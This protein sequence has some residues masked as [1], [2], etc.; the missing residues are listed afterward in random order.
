MCERMSLIQNTVLAFG[1]FRSM[2]QVASRFEWRDSLLTCRTWM[3][4]W[5]WIALNTTPLHTRASERIAVNQ[6]LSTTQATQPPENSL[7]QNPVHWNIGSPLVTVFTAQTAAAESFAVR[8][9]IRPG[10][11]RRPR[12]LSEPTQWGSHLDL[13]SK[14]NHTY[15]ARNL[16][17]YVHGS[18]Q[19]AKIADCI[20]A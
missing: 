20:V 6:R 17:M 13:N 14:A 4:R 7:R 2:P 15:F 3:R 8:L 10:R 16:S 1:S 5:Q 11:S 19:D 18:P 12:T 9:T